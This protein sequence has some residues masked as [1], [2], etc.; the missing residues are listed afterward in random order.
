MSQVNDFNTGIIE[1][2]RANHGVVGGPFD[3][4]AARAADD[5]GG[6]VGPDAGEPAGDAAR[7]RHAVRVRLEGRGAD[8]P[9]LV[10]TTWSRIQRSRWSTAT[11]SSTPWPTS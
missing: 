5:D 10:L 6:E 1:E 8:E 3:G 4:C 2:F 7:G 11:R 9:G